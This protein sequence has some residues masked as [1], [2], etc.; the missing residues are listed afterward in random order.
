MTSPAAPGSPNPS[1]CRAWCPTPARPQ[2]VAVRGSRRAG[3]SGEAGH[4]HLA[5]VHDPVG[6]TSGRPD[7]F[8]L[9]AQRP[10]DPIR[11]HHLGSGQEVDDR[12]GHVSGSRSVGARRAGAG[13]SSKSASPVNAAAHVRP[14]LLGRR[15]HGRRNDRPR[16]GRP[17]RSD[18][19]APTGF[20]RAP[21]HPSGLDGGDVPAAVDIGP[22]GESAR[23]GSAAD[24]DVV[25]EHERGGRHAPGLLGRAPRRVLA[26]AEVGGGTSGPGQSRW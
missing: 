25:G 15:H 16:A 7:P 24:A 5:L 20:P 21:P 13:R 4:R 6:P 8:E 22:A 17:A 18:P 14:L 2:P 23:F 26:V 10:A 9:T 19:T 3:T 1:T 12:D 11:L